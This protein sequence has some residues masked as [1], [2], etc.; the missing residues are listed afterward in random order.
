MFSTRKDTF[1][2]VVS[3]NE[4]SF[5]DALSNCDTDKGLSVKTQSSKVRTLEDHAVKNTAF[6]DCFSKVGRG[7]TDVGHFHTDEFCSDQPGHAE[8][9]AHK[10]DPLKLASARS[11]A[12]RPQS[13]RPA[14]SKLAS[15]KSLALKCAPVRSCA[16][17]IGA[18][19]S[20][21][22]KFPFMHGNACK[23]AFW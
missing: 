10:I 11:I 1:L 22:F 2:S 9:C 18:A 4:T 17:K 13:D 23:F 19:Q 20:T 12:C 5:I 3:L 14:P 16:C 21:N 15:R 6:E 7:K 8:I